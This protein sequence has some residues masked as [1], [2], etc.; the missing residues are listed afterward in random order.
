LDRRNEACRVKDIL[1]SFSW[2]ERVVV[3]AWIY[4]EKRVD[5]EAVGKSVGAGHILGCE[6]RAKAHVLVG[7]KMKKIRS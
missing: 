6:D 2:E 7:L 3:V 1:P 5:G 4:A